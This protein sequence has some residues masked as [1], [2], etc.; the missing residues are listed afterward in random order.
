MTTYS[1]QMC[2]IPTTCRHRAKNG[3]CTRAAEPGEPRPLCF[4]AVAL[5]VITDESGQIVAVQAVADKSRPAD[6]IF[7]ALPEHLDMAPE[8]DK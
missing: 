7:A 5:T 8:A 1:G 3:H 2:L 4:H 6:D